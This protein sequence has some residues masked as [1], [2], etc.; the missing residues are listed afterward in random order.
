MSFDAETSKRRRRVRVTRIPTTSAAMSLIWDG[1]DLVD[2]LGGWRRWDARGSETPGRVNWTYPFDQAVMSPSGRFHVIYAERGTKALVLDNGRVVRELNRSFRHAADY[3]YPVAVGRLPDGREIVAHCP[4][5][6]NLLQI[7]DLPSGRCLTTGA[8]T[9]VDVFHSRLA[10]SPDGR[11][12]LMAGWVWHPYGVGRVFDLQQALTD[13]SVLDSP[14]VADLYQAVDAEVA[15]ACWLD[16]DR[17][18]IATT[19]EEALNGEDPDALSP[20]QLGVWS[21]TAGAWQQRTTLTHP[22]GTMIGCGEQI[23]TLH[24]QPRLV[25]LTGTVVAEWPDVAV[26]TKTDS[27]GAAHLPTPIAALHPSQ[28][29][30][31]VAQP[32]H[33]AV[34][35]LPAG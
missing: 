21:M 10:V 11:Y 14:G 34:I 4:D 6:Y 2:V 35:H 17:V 20:G 33:I 26:S 19:T 25:D 31:A 29:R 23:I 15:A 32:D 27:Y 5:R 9:P 18:V 12:L 22:A 16:D 8:R 3:D 7:E 28:R 30:L 1:D 24:G 13:P